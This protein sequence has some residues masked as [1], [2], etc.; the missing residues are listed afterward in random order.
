[1]NSSP[2]EVSQIFC[3]NNCYSAR[4]DT[5]IQTPKRQEKLPNPKSHKPAH[6]HLEPLRLRVPGEDW[7]WVCRVSIPENSSRP[8]S[9]FANVRVN[10]WTAERRPQEGRTWVGTTQ[11]QSTLESDIIRIPRHSVGTRSVPPLV[12]LLP[13]HTA[14]AQACMDPGFYC[15]V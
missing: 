2:N 10:A 11:K 7:S 4:P 15:L 6:K 12:H 3:K 9:N 8:I 13:H 1:M 5:A 14:G